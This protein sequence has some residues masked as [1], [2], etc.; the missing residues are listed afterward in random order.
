MDDDVLGPILKRLLFT[1]VKNTDFSRLFGYHP[2]QF[3]TL[4]LGSFVMFVN[5]KL[6]PNEGL[7]LDMSLEKSSVMGYRTLF[8]GTGIHH[9][10]AVLQI[11]H[12]MYISGF[13]I[14]LLDLTPDQG[15][16][17]GRTSHVY[18]GEIMIELH[19]P[20]HYLTRLI[21]CCT[22]NMTIVFV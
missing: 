9:S 18:N 10:N 22:W 12:D 7:S 17:E 16:S 14:L 8:D 15:V 3:S 20:S 5:G 21:V 1:M 13:F 6:V 19:L 4:N 11:T 2:V